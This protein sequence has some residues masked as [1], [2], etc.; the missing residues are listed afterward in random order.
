MLRRVSFPSKKSGN[1]SE[2]GVGGHQSEATGPDDYLTLVTTKH[3]L[4]LGGLAFCM[5]TPY[6]FQ[7]GNGN[8]GESQHP[9]SPMDSAGQTFRRFPTGSPGVAIYVFEASKML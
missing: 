2:S 5:E 3:L 6:Q 7:T 1:P 4:S 9:I 8:A